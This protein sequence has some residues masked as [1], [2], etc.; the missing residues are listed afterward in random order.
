MALC[1]HAAAG[2][3]GTSGRDPEVGIRPSSLLFT[4]H[5]DL[6]D[7]IDLGPGPSGRGQAGGH[8][9]AQAAALREE[10]AEPFGAQLW[11]VRNVVVLEPYA[12]C[13]MLVVCG[14]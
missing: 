13:C 4:V 14:V 3:A 8:I 12:R 5:S 1:V 9:A 11:R 7:E 10:L 6:D 2:V